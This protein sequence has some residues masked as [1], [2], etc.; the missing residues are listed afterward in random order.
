MEDAPVRLADYGWQAEAFGYLS[1]PAIDLEAPIYLGGASEKICG[2]GAVVGRPPLPIGGENTPLH[3]GG[4]PQLA[5]RGA[6][7][8]CGEAASR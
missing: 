8:A 2:G 7:S 4:P 1:I 5:G 6:V 3:H